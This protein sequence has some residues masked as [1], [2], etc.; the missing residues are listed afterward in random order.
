MPFNE[1]DRRAY[2]AGYAKGLKDGEKN[3]YDAGFAALAALIRETGWTEWQTRRYLC[4]AR[5]LL[6]AAG[7]PPWELSSLARLLAVVRLVHPMTERDEVNRAG[8]AFRSL[9]W[10]PKDVE[11]AKTDLRARM[12]LKL[13]AGDVLMVADPAEWGEP[14][15]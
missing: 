4:W 10:L 8:H 14:H 12:L 9:N 1:T 3:D 13:R 15:V 5:N 7:Q 6:L 2:D 11:Q